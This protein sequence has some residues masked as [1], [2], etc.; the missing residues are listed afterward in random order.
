[1]TDDKPHPLKTRLRIACQAAAGFAIMTIG[2]L[3]TLLVAILTLFA[4]GDS[5]L[6][7]A[8]PRPHGLPCALAA[9]ALLSMMR[10]DFMADNLCLSPTTLRRWMF[11]FSQRCGYRILASS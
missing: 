6:T 10:T 7:I 11:S 4:R 5:T 9:S 1:M 3:V 2:S 8:L